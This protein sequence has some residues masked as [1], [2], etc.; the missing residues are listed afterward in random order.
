M[1]SNSTIFDEHFLVQPPNS[2]HPKHEKQPSC[3][4]QHRF[5]VKDPFAAY[6]LKDGG[7]PFLLW[8]YTTIVGS[9]YK[10]RYIHFLWCCIDLYISIYSLRWFFVFLPHFAYAS[11]YLIVSLGSLPSISCYQYYQCDCITATCLHL[12]CLL[13]EVFTFVQHKDHKGFSGDFFW[14]WFS[15]HHFS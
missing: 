8:D 13:L 6:L 5:G 2:I 11:C 12:S 9:T 7:K 4:P 1:W 3:L 10:Y 15:K 14:T